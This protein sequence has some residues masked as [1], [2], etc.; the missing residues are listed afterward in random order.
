MKKLLILISILFCL[1]SFSQEKIITTEIEYNYI[2]NS[3]SDD[4]ENG[5]DIKEGY[6]LKDLS[7]IESKNF[8]F[9]FYKFIK[10]EDNTTRAVY[11]RIEKKGKNKVRHLC[12][13][14]NN[15]DL[16]AEF[17]KSYDKLGVQMQLET[18]VVIFAMLQSLLNEKLNGN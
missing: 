18:E 5:R 11:L 3:Y 6:E 12:I 7:S 16:L 13:P 4:V 8:K 1:N 10:T 2:T 15:K 9:N 14:F 17:T